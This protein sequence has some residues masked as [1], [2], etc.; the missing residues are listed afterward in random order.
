ME[1]PFHFRFQHSLDHHLGDAIRDSRYP[2]RTDPSVRLGNLDPLD[3]RRHVTARRHP[4]PQLVEV[5]PQL[6]LE[7]L[8]RLVV[9]ACPALVGSHSFVGFPHLPFGDGEGLRLSHESPPVA[10]CSLDPSRLRQPLR[11]R[12]VTGP[13]ALLQAAPSLYAASVLCRSRDLRLR[14][15]LAIGVT[16]S[17]VPHKSPDRVL[18]ASMPDADRAVSRYPSDSSRSRTPPPVLT[19]PVIVSTRLQ[20]F[21]CVRLHGPHLTGLARLFP[22]RSPPRLLNAAAVG[23]LKPPPARRLRGTFPHLLCSMAAWRASAPLCTFVAHVYVRFLRLAP[24]S[25]LIDFPRSPH[26]DET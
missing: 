18:A 24:S 11:S 4:V 23:G 25:R 16:G 26:S 5:G 22:T 14:V 9:H 17:H 13:S 20:R 1:H 8:Q 12:P 15:S 10:G 3:R 6:L 2:Q 21:T 19:P 7:L